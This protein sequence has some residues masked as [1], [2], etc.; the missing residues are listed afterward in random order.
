MF[1]VYLYDIRGKIRAKNIA[2]ILIFI[3][4]VLLSTLRFRVGGDALF[5]EDF[6]PHMPDLSSV[7]HFLQNN[8][9][10]NYQPFWIMLVAICKSIFN[11]VIFFQLV[12]SLIFDIIL[13]IFI[14]RYS[15]KPFT[16]IT[17]MF[18][19][20]LYFYYSF[21]IQRESIAVGVFLLNI[22]NLE[23]KKWIPYYFWALFSF[24][25]HISAVILFFLPL[26]NY[27]K[28]NQTL[29][30]VSLLMSVLVYIFK[31][32]I[33][34][35]ILSVLFLDVMKSRM[36]VYAEMKFSL[37]GFWSFYFVRVFLLIPI[38]LFNIKENLHENRFRWFYPTF[39]IASILAQFFV[40]FE[41][42]LNYMIPV[43]LILVVDF[44][45]SYYSK[46]DS[47]VKKSI[48]AVSVVLHVFFILDY[49]LF[50]INDYG[51][52][53]YSLFFPYTSVFEPVIIPERENF[54]MN[55]FE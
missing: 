46:I 50:I 34:D 27:I 14:R 28:F 26:F 54:Y 32:E 7:F 19:S 1:C 2:Y 10:I 5:Y 45:Y 6:F 15:S 8:N 20:L 39:F 16:V 37:L 25:F 11:N 51:Q 38:M 21:E 35:L 40:G 41:R 30:F 55:V 3:I 12:H 22:K 42:L 36:Q 29:L 18:V 53:Y 23:N 44:F 4:F 33:L 49:K 48:I 17:V 24:M 43:Y 13:F 9:Y 52:H 47:F 31:T